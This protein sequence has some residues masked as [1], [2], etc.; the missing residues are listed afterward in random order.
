MAHGSKESSLP[1]VCPMTQWREEA[2]AA[3]VTIIPEHPRP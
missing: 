1:Q 2:F 3:L